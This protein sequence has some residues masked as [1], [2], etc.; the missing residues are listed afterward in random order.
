M[1][2]LFRALQCSSRFSVSTREGRREKGGAVQ[3]AGKTRDGPGHER[4]EG[5]KGGRREGRLSRRQ[6]VGPS[7]GEANRQF[8]LRPLCLSVGD[9]GKKGGGKKHKKGRTTFM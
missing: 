7:L 4:P 9:G 5:R 1:S 2:V 8:W 6:S 3:F